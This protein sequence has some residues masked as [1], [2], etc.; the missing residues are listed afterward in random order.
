MVAFRLL[1]T[2]MPY[3]CCFDDPSLHH[4]YVYPYPFGH[5]APTFSRRY[6]YGRACHSFYGC[7]LPHT[8]AGAGAGAGAG[9]AGAAGAA[10]VV[11]VVA[12]VADAAAGAGVDE[13]V[14]V[15]DS[16]VWALLGRRQSQPLPQCPSPGHSIACSV[17]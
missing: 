4:L 3:S 5:L 12:V 11:A 9:A 1:A 7:S 13:Y 16:N 10:G 17:F 2:K 8:L 15:H 6:H 14:V